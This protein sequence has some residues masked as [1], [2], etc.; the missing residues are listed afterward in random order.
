MRR[1][2][3]NASSTFGMRDARGRVA[4]APWVSRV[5]LSTDVTKRAPSARRRKAARSAAWLKPRRAARARCSG[6]GTT[7]D[8]G[9]RRR[10]WMRRAAGARERARAVEAVFVL[11]RRDRDGERATIDERRDVVVRLVSAARRTSVAAKEE[12]I[13]PMIGVCS[14]HAAQTSGAR[15]ETGDS[16]ARRTSGSGRGRAGEEIRVGISIRSDRSP[17]CYVKSY[18]RLSPWRSSRPLVGP[19]SRKARGL[20]TTRDREVALGDPFAPHANLLHDAQARRV[21]RHDTPPA[22]GGGARRRTR[23]RTP[24]PPLRS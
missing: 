13:V 17:N 7:C 24:P 16:N 19:S 20:P 10:G 8:G 23:T 2:A 12:R 11:Q 3:T 4:C 18:V 6:T 14:S 5:R 22:R 9:S 21:P 1:R 15:S